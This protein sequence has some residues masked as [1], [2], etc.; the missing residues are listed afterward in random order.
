[1]TLYGVPIVAGRQVHYGRID[2]ELS[3]ELFLRHAL[4]EGD[5]DTSHDFF[6][7]NRRLLAEV[8]ELE[9]RARRRDIVVDD[10]SLFDFYDRRVPAEVV[11]ARHFDAWWK[12]AGRERPDL[13][14]FERSMLIE[15]AAVAPD[16]RDYPDSWHQDGHRLRLTYQFE[17]GSDADGVT[18]HIPL[19]VLN[20]VHPDGFDWQVP[21]L[22]QELVT[23]LLRSLPK[24]IRRN[25]VP[26]PN[27]AGSLLRR[28]GPGDGPLLQV[29]AR[30]LG[31]AGPV[32]VPAHA[33]DL[34]RVPDHLRMTFR[35]E[36]ERGRGPAAK[37]GEGKDLRELQARLAPRLRAA[38]A[39]AA[40]GL[41]RDRLATWDLGTLPR[42]V[43]QR[44]GGRVVR[45]YPALVEEG[46]GVAVRV[47]ESEAEQADAMWAGTRRLLLQSIPSPARFVLGRQSTKAKLTLSGSRH[48][49]PSE[50]F[51][52]CLAA[53]ADDLIAANGGPA[54]DQEGFRRLHDAVRAGLAEA[55]LDVVTRVERVLAVAAAVEGRLAELTNPAFWPA[56]DDLRVQLDDLV[57]PGWVAAT[58]RRRLPDVLRYLR[59]MVQRLD[60]LPGDLARDR[61]RMASVARVTD[62]WHRLLDLAPGS[63]PPAAALT[64]IRWMLEELRVS[65]FAQTLGT[66]YPVS[67]K[68][69]LRAIDQL[70]A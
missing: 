56:R 31:R 25:F 5:W 43:E 55:T 18:V 67:E 59:A 30:E 68:R 39:V 45:G 6:A 63:R 15:D 22:R 2:P 62:A 4:V 21:G 16:A 35:V 41:E 33:F 12:R 36:E 17:P 47:L 1:V 64:G 32:E 20:Q 57:Y 48:G 23:A 61:Q 19:A 28:I 26:A 50:L 65:Y 38:L 29:L 60:R 27:W 44:R 51:A 8:E 66:P 46:D 10:H 53:A 40:P 24:V 7:R 70:T 49:S 3:R 9:H 52:D 42:V 54:W 69:I 34:T 11:S 37:L 58:G 13:L 14:D